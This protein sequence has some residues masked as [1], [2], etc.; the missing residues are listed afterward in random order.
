MRNRVALLL[1]IGVFVAGVAGVAVLAGGNGDGVAHGDLPK[2]P[3]GAASAQRGEAAAASADMALYPYG[4]IE[5]RLARPL[6]K[7]AERAAAFKGAAV[8]ADDVQPLADALGLQAPARDDDGWVA[9]GDAGE[10][11]VDRR[12][13]SWYFGPGPDIAVSSP[14][15]G[16]C[17][18]CPPDVVCTMDCKPMGKP[19]GMPSQSEAEVVA[20]AFWDKAAITVPGAGLAVEDHFS[21]WYVH[22]APTYEGVPVRGLEFSVGVGPHK[23]IQSAGGW[24]GRADKLGDYPLI[25]TED[26]VKR[27]NNPPAYPEPGASRD[28]PADD[29][30]TAQGKGEPGSTGSAGATEPAPPPDQPKK[31][32]PTD[33]DPGIEPEPQPEPRPEPTPPVTI[34]P[35]PPPDPEP[36]VVTLTSV[37]LVLQFTGTHLVPA[38][39]FTSDGGEFHTVPAVPDEHLHTDPRPEVLTGE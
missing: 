38:Y 5:F 26:A 39:E 4:R 35:M 30:G 9:K 24:L 32:E 2:L 36:Q 22:V 33:P 13:G 7:P 29:A 23:A 10:L 12:T 11:R 3:F 16:E 18:P 17:R 20:R 37:R 28:L 1:S 14:S 19:A 31:P 6:D 27:M 15:I 34:E 25:S 21:M 8:D